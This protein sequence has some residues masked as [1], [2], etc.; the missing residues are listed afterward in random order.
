MPDPIRTRPNG[1]PHNMQQPSAGAQVA[2][3]PPMQHFVMNNGRSQAVGGPP[4][5]QP[6]S[7]VSM[8]GPAKGVPRRGG[9]AAL[10]AFQREP[11]PPVSPF[12]L[13]QL[14]L[15]RELVQTFGLHQQEQPD[16]D[17]ATVEMAADT[18][19]EIDALLETMPKPKPTAAERLGRPSPVERPS[20]FA[21]AAPRRVQRAAP[22]VVPAPPALEDEPPAAG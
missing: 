4:G 21:P 7:N 2:V 1:V 18:I 8:M 10:P 16:G 14:L 13:D 3:S 6:G 17:V 22:A 9:Q 20:A 11:A 19:D 15:I 12:T 5:G